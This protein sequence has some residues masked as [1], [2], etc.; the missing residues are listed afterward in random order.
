DHVS[1]GSV[2]CVS[3]SMI[4]SL[5]AMRA[6]SEHRGTAHV[7]AQ[8][9]V[10]GRLPSRRVRSGRETVGD[11]V[12]RRRGLST[13]RTRGGAPSLDRRIRG[14]R[15]RRGPGAGGGSDSPATHSIK[16]KIHV[17]IIANPARLLVR[18]RAASDGSGR[19]TLQS[20]IYANGTAVRRP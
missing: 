10:E 8:V 15:P 7:G 17:P 1:G 20:E 13:T 19:I 2:M 4:Q 12:Q 18:F 5:R 3:A 11:V 16:L 14:R 9:E 6:S